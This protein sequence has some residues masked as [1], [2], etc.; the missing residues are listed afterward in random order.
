[1]D[2]K[3]YLSKVSNVFAENR[4]LKFTVVVLGLSLLFFGVEVRQAVNNQKIIL[5]PLTL[6]DE[7]A[8]DGNSVSD[9]YLE[10]MT[11]Y[12]M[13]LAV[14]Y[15][16]AT[17]RGNFDRLLK[18]FRPQEF[19]AARKTFYELASSVEVSKNTTAFFI[20]KISVDRK[21]GEIEVSGTR[22]QFGD[23]S[24]LP[25]SGG[26]K[27]YYIDYVVESGSFMITNFSEKSS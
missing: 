3:L 14:N 12:V 10:K 20:S 17:A 21:K 15:T 22:K 6:T 13:G 2:H 26:L 23:S 7:T 27:V 18:L 16:P 5:V 24:A 19:P 4:L 25:D 11:R 9:D 8:I 1:M